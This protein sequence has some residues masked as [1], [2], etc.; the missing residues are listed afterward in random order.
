MK[1]IKLLF[2]FFLFCTCCITAQPPKKD[3]SQLALKGPVKELEI[4]TYVALDNF[5]KPSKGDRVND[6]SSYIFNASGNQL[7]QNIYNKNGSLRIRCAYQYNYNGKLQ[8]QNQYI[9]G[10]ALKAKFTYKYNSQG[11]L[12]EQNMLKPDGS[13]ISKYT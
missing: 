3:L 1:P 9:P 12:N 7:E 5:G 4:R 6:N 8:E 11:A 2:L 13:L 10:G